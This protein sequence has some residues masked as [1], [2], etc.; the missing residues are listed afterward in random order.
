M[1]EFNFND[2]LQQTAQAAFPQSNQSSEVRFFQLKNSGDEALV[3]FKYSN[4][5]EFKCFHTHEVM[6]EQGKRRVI[7]CTRE[8]LDQLEKCPL[9]AERKE[10]KDKFYV[11]MI[12]YE[13][14]PT[15]N[16]V[17]VCPKIWERSMSMARKI[18]GLINEYGPLEDYVF[19][20]KR[21]GEGLQTTYDILFC[22]PKVY[23][24]AVYKKDFSSFD[25]FKILGRFVKE[26]TQTQP[27]TH[28]PTT[29]TA[30]NQ[31][32]VEQAQ[33]TFSIDSDYSPIDFSTSS[34][35][36]KYDYDF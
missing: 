14:D 19:K 10:I 25:D 15:T 16:T 30:V 7:N 8:R 20:I 21:N 29:P 28:Q 5:S 13:V 2:Y 26:Q 24:D 9:C 31:V 32:K 35:S 12:Q 6:D 33:E 3:R 18:A 23:T 17:S 36:L 11:E 22:N 27:T 34:A 1:S 4:T